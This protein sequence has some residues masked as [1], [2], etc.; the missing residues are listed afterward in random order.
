MTEMTKTMM[1]VAAAVVSLLAAFIIR[2]VGNTFDVQELVGEKLNQFDIEAPKRLKIIKFDKDTASVREFEVAEQ[3]NLWVIPSKRDYP[4]DA[5]RQMGEAAAGVTN[6]EILRIATQNPEQHA[7]LGVVSPSAPRLTPKSEGVGIRVVMYDGTGDKLADMIVGK[8]VKDADE[9]RYVRNSDQD[10][11][12]VVQL[13]PK[14]LSTNFEDWIEDDLLKINPLDIRQ[15]QIKDYSAEL[16]LT[17]AGAQ[18]NWDRRGKFTFRY[19][20]SESKWVPESLLKFDPDAQ[21]YVEDAIGENEQVNDEALQSLRDGL[22]DL[23]I[24]DVERKPDGLS[25]DLKA[26]ND[27]LKNEAAGSL[28]NRGFA[29]VAVGEGGQPEILSSEGELTCTLQ[30]GVEYVL[31]FG[32]LKID[33]DDS[34]ATTSEEEIDADGNEAIHRYL[35]VMTRFNQE[36]IEKPKLQ[37]LPELPESPKPS[38]SAEPSESTEEATAEGDTPEASESSE[39]ESDT[40][41]SNTEES[42]TEE[43]TGE[44]EKIVAARKMIEAENQRL[45]DEYK[46]KIE[47][48]NKRVQQLNERFGDWYYVI[49]NDVYKKIHLGRGQLVAE[50]EQEADGEAAE[51]DTG[52]P[53]QGLP[54]LPGA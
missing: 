22:D 17:L 3:D 47:D 42:N 33:G 20:D 50:K 40:E 37:D 36:M 14:A 38:E 46:Q 9:Q 13:D 27:F 1:F 54:N 15:V 48:G 12:Y 34:S 10:I 11:V 53:L 49:S 4:A 31:R 18:I 16:L 28:A 41:E 6:L 44:L 30:N 52:N 43:Q 39:G 8:S 35:F 24:V 32:N 5:E 29:P 26:G 23:L 25:A 19:D 2:P 51:S 21:K 7:E 45:L